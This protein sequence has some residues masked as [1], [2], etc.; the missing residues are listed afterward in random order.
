M[1]CATE[2]GIMRHA[3]YP[4]IG[5]H[6]TAHQYLQDTF[7]ANVR[8]FIR[9]EAPEVLAVCTELFHDHMLNHDTKF[10]LF[11]NQ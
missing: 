9:G 4:D 1:H 2:E 7:I 8:L 10:L 5:E 3:N 11:I 6:E